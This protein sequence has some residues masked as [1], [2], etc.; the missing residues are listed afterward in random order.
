MASYGLEYRADIAG[1]LFGVLCIE[2]GDRSTPALAERCRCF[3]LCSAPA[4]IA[5][6]SA[7]HWPSLLWRQ[8]KVLFLNQLMCFLGLSEHHCVAGT[9]M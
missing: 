6:Q 4:V 7:N 9:N 2:L 8:R 5:L 3:A 1:D